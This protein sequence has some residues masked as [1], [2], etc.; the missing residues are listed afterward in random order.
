[1]K[2]LKTLVVVALLA[3]LAGGVYVSIYHTPPIDEQ[4]ASSS[5]EG[6]SE[7]VPRTPE[8]P[9]PGSESTGRGPAPPFQANFSDEVRVSMGDPFDTATLRHSSGGNS[10]AL[11]GGGAVAALSAAPAGANSGPSNATPL[12]GR[13][14]G[15]TPSGGDSA[16]AKERNLAQAGG[17]RERL[18]VEP[19][20]GSLQSAVTDRP[21]NPSTSS[22]SSTGST[23]AQLPDFSTFMAAIQREIQQGNLADALEKLSLYYDQLSPGSVERQQI[24]HLLD[25]IAYAVIY[26]PQSVLEPPYVVQPG[27]TLPRIAQSYGVPWQLL[28]RINGIS[29]PANLVPGQRLKVLRGPFDADLDT[30]TRELTLRLQG[31]YAGRF[32][33]LAVPD[34]NQL[35]SSL[36]VEDKSGANEESF[37]IKLN[38]RLQ[39]RGAADLARQQPSPTN[40]V[41][42]VEQDQIQNLHTI[43]S[44]GSRLRVIR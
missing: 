27:D 38:D 5:P 18:G 30:R 11:S 39:I 37:W 32:N 43:L 23:V 1:M 44:V 2:S 24:M 35:G 31:L 34:T 15:E 13:S 28:A 20:V 33:L 3:A 19:R 41:I 10:Q 12:S 16:F 4:T 14:S 6:N 8:F 42:A 7:S 26:S 40:Q 21:V 9:V 36:F 29:D 17:T 25:Q 22:T